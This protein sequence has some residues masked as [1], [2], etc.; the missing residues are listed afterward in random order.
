MRDP[1][2]A[3]LTRTDADQ[4]ATTTRCHAPSADLG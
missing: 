2:L 4:G 3:R 1:Q